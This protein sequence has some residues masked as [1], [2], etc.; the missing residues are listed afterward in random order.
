MKGGG[1]GVYAEND[2]YI[3]VQK[4]S[5]SNLYVRVILNDEDAGDQT[6]SGA[7]QDE[8]VNGTLTASIQYQRAVNNV[9]GPDPAFTIATGSTL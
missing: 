5:T 7:A 6:G 1:S 9:V 8:D 4:T 3:V 2:Y